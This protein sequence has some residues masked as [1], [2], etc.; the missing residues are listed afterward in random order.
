MKFATLHSRLNALGVTT[1]ALGSRVRLDGSVNP[2]GPKR[3]KANQGERGSRI[4]TANDCLLPLSPSL[5]D[6]AHVH[7]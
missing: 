1:R 2:A 5:P 4:V 7:I 3:T 6:D